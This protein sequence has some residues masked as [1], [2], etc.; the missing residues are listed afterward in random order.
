MAYKKKEKM[1]VPIPL[2][3]K[4]MDDA[5]FRELLAAVGAGGTSLEFCKKRGID[6]ISLR[7]YLHA[8]ARRWSILKKAEE[9][10][11]AVISD[12]FIRELREISSTDI[13]KMFGENGQL[14]PVSKWPDSVGNQVKSVKFSDKTGE[15]VSIEF[16]S[17][18]SGLQMI[19]KSLGLTESKG[20]KALSL[21]EELVRERRQR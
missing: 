12:I 1:N 3:G 21:I 5:S 6:Y 17:K 18:L 20:D 4:A 2:G 8:D 13:R 9:S 15:I 16:Y 19:G 7:D 14:L 10:R 11:A